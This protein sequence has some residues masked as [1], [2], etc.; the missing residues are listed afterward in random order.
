MDPMN[1]ER[2]WRYQRGTWSEMAA[3]I[4]FEDD[5]DEMLEEL[6]GYASRTRWFGEE[7]EFAV[8]VYSADPDASP[9]PPTPYLVIVYNV[10]DNV[11]RVFIEDFPSLMQFLRETAPVLDLNNFVWE[12]DEDEDLFGDDEEKE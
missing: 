6:P 3:P 11:E 12:L 10:G 2:V 4:E 1:G 5:E 9:A 7:N 8:E